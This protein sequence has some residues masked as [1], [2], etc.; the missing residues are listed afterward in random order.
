MKIVGYVIFGFGLLFA[1]S[2]L[3]G[4]RNN[5]RR[6]LGVQRGT[7]NTTMLF[8]VSL[9]LVPI[10]KLSPL[11]LLWMFP[12]SFILGTLSLA[13]PFSL[14]SIP[15]SL[16]FGIACLGLNRFEVDQN[17]A[18]Y[19][20]LLELMRSDNISVEQAKEKLKATGQW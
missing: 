6:G 7:V 3:A 11:H 1:L 10:L 5:T 13:F 16:I 12:V 4:I 9:A 17:R 14:L 18:R 19:E 2:F 15:G 20:K 8:V